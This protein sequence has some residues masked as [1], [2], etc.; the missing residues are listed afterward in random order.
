MMSLTRSGAIV[1]DV[2][3]TGT[4][5][6]CGREEH[7]PL[8]S[9]WG[10]VPGRQSMKYS[11][12]SDWGLLS[13][14][15]S[16]RSEPQPDWVMLT[17]TW[18]SFDL[19]LGSMVRSVIFPARTP[20]ILASPPLTRP[21]A[22]SSSTQY[23]MPELPPPLAPRARKVK[24]PRV[25]STK[26]LARIRL[27]GLGAS[28]AELGGGAVERIDRFRKRAAPR[29]PIGLHR[30]DRD[31]ADRHRA[32]SQRDQILMLDRIANQ[33]RQIPKRGTRIMRERPQLRQ[34]RAQPPSHRL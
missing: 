18:A 28:E 9:A 16:L 8:D 1:D 19:P 20:A 29:L 30:T 27:M 26:A 3:L 5:R 11:P 15:T 6:S 31:I 33:R 7:S 21:N 23:F 12:I 14:V 32:L 25:P 24:I 22:L 34:K 2:W 10:E 4:Q 17:W 13:Q